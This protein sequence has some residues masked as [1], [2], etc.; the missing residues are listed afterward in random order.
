MKVNS[1]GLQTLTYLCGP[2]HSTEIPSP[3]IGL[4]KQR[5][6]NQQKEVKLPRL[7]SHNES[8]ALI[9]LDSDA[10]ADP[11]SSTSRIQAISDTHDADSETDQEETVIARP[12]RRS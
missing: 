9:D 7:R 10:A 8:E 5:A 2:C 12:R 4:K 6:S 11:P 1:C 3:E